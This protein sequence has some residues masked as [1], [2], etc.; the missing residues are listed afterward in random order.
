MRPASR[1]LQDQRRQRNARLH[2]LRGARP[3][4]PQVHHTQQLPRHPPAQRQA[5]N[6]AGPRGASL[7]AHQ[8]QDHSHRHQTRKRFDLRRRRPHSKN[9]GR[10]HLLSPHGD[11]VA[12]F[13]GEHRSQGA[14]RG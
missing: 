1:R 4:P 5:H 11:E 10:R 14:P 12:G 13:S 9:R 8:V 6:E 3:Q 7:S 2:G